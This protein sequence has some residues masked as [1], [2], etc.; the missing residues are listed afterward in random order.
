M[1]QGIKSRRWPTIQITACR[2]LKYRCCART[3]IGAYAYAYYA[4]FA[5]V[6]EL[7][8]PRSML[9]ARVDALRKKRRNN[10]KTSEKRIHS[11]H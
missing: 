4:G 5:L 8:T 6:Q 1:C 3:R 9:Y 7:L 2:V 11:V 10:A